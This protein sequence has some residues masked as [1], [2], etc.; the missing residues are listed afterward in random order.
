MVTK[1]ALRILGPVA[2]FVVVAGLYCMLRLKRFFPRPRP[3][4]SS[5]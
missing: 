1:P 4:Q 2:L 5:R 3:E